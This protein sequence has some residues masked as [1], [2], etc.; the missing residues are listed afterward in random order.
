MNRILH[1]L[2]L[3][4]TSLVA[5]ALPA[6]ASPYTRLAI[7]IPL[8]MEPDMMGVHVVKGY[9]ND[10]LVEIKTYD[11][12]GHCTFSKEIIGGGFLCMQAI[13]FDA[14]GK[15]TRQV[16]VTILN[17]VMAL[18]EWRFTPTTVQNWAPMPVPGNV[19]S[20]AS[21]QANR[22]C[23]IDGYPHSAAEMLKH[24]PIQ[25]AL[26]GEMT[27]QIQ[28]Q[29][30][31]RGDLLQSEGIDSRG[32][33]YS[34]E[35]FT[36]NASGHCLSSRKQTS[37]DTADYAIEQHILDPQGDEVALYGL[38]VYHGHIDT[39]Y[40]VISAYRDHN[41]LTSVRRI[42]GRNGTL[43]KHESFS[44]DSQGHLLRHNYHADHTDALI[45]YALRTYDAKH[46][47]LQI[48]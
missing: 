4:L 7:P 14:A 10:E 30:N 25:A 9:L 11:G 37:S 48:D 21:M 39:S 41:L 5:F 22:L 16:V 47:L 34:T 38:N 15:P 35:T 1:T 45:G 13:D 36:Y 6:F 17:G 33:A 27:L 2:I 26:T 29:L 32:K 18:L 19:Q 44:Y 46:R 31:A 8:S 40:V 3:G 12:K 24:A 42:G 20:A 28:Q 43:L 23:S